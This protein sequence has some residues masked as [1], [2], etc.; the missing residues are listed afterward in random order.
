MEQ[1]QWDQYADNERGI[2]QKTTLD[3]DN[4][5]CSSSG[6]PV[7][8]E[9][10]IINSKSLLPAHAFFL[11]LHEGVKRSSNE[12][13]DDGFFLSSVSILSIA[14]L[15]ISW[16]M[17]SC[18]ASI[19]TLIHTTII[20]NLP[21]HQ[22][23]AGTTT[24]T[25]RSTAI[26][27]PDSS[28]SLKK[29]RIN[30]NLPLAGGSEITFSPKHHSH[31]L[32]LTES[33]RAELKNVLTE[34]THHVASAVS[35]MPTSEEL[36]KSSHSPES[37]CIISWGGSWGDNNQAKTH[38]HDRE[39][40]TKSKRKRKHEPQRKHKTKTQ[41]LNLRRQREQKH[42]LNLKTRQ[43]TLT[44]H[45]FNPSKLSLR[46][47]HHSTHKHTIRLG[48]SGGIWCRFF[49]SPISS[50]IWLRSSWTHAQTTVLI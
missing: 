50:K 29:V 28:G 22:P 7:D 48:R 20:H 26:L 40:R 36:K 25:D 15:L 14:Y 32:R 33:D 47:R 18:L 13:T 9:V 1:Q 8:T 10:T 35:S 3:T 38:S 45:T 43:K 46:L 44:E 16:S 41:H 49:P 42:L 31:S 12:W 19:L 39:Q 2:R 4:T 34:F 21:E 23:C 24:T 6:T 30:P 5:T 17:L 27:S 11:P 37:C